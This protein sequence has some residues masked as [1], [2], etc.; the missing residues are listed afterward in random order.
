MRKTETAFRMSRQEQAAMFHLSSESTRLQL[1]RRCRATERTC[2]HRV[3]VEITIP[4]TSR[5]ITVATIKMFLSAN[6]GA[7]A[8][9]DDFGRD[10]PIEKS[11]RR[12]SDRPTGH[13]EQER[14]LAPSSFKADDR[15]GIR[16]WVDI[17]VDEE[18]LNLV[19]RR[20][21]CTIHR[22]G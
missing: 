19:F 21:D 6:G 3:A 15:G 7:Q 20:W 22:T 18:L 10:W 12:W 8:V 17:V 9:L 4:L 2:C 5:L 1:Y 16:N 14:D 11:R 13:E